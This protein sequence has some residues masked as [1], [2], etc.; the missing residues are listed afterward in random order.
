MR[1][2]DGIIPRRALSLARRRDVVARHALRVARRLHVP[3]RPRPRRPPVEQRLRG[4]LGRRERLGRDAR[5]AAP[6]RGLR[7]AH[8]AE[9]QGATTRWRTTRDAPA[10]PRRAAPAS[11]SRRLASRRPPSSDARA[12]SSSRVVVASSPQV[13][14]VRHDPPSIADALRFHDVHHEPSVVI[15]K[16]WQLDDGDRGE[17]RWHDDAVHV[18]RVHGDSCAAIGKNAFGRFVAA[19]YLRCVLY[20]SFSPIARFQHLI[21]SLFN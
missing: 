20:K 4:D 6:G 5:G 13:W 19:G 21:A 8:R 14:G 9:V 2:R 17:M 16:G 15:G 1:R 18:V 11:S 10:P 12:S 7:E 3:R